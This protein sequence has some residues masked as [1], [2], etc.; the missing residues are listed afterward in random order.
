MFIRDCNIPGPDERPE[1][2]V[3]W[4]RVFDGTYNS[5]G[6]EILA[7]ITSLIGFHIPFTAK[8]CLD[9]TNNMAENKACTYDIEASIDLRIKI[10]EVF[11]DSAL[12]IIKSEEIGKLGIRS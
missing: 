1:P 3:R 7:V 4:T 5:K 8:L 11:G 6:H 12:V 9:S 10:L 2:G